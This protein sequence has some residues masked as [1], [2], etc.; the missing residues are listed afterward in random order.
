MND[1]RL[2]SVAREKEL[3]LAILRIEHGRARTSASKLSISSV[4]KEAGISGALIHNHYPEIAE[5]VRV[6]QG[7]SSRQQR[8]AKVDQLKMQRD[9]LKELKLELRNVQ[10]QVRTLASINEMLLAEINVLRALSADQKV[11]RLRPPV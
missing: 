6:K 5:E 2:T 1:K 3:R 10:L 8:D 4:A 11:A 9:Q 7:A